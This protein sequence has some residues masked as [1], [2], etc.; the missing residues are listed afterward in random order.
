MYV[1]QPYSERASSPTIVTIK[2][3][4]DETATIYFALRQYQDALIKDVRNRTS[5]HY[6]DTT[7]STLQEELA[8]LCHTLGEVSRLLF[9]LTEDQN[10]EFRE[11][12][13]V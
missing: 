9:E 8:F 7:P 10:P 4:R 5:K 12:L 1:S 13:D 11:W 3:T 6:A 2:A